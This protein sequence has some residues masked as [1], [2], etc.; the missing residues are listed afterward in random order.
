MSIRLGGVAAVST[1][2]V[3]GVPG[4][5]LALDH[6]LAEDAADLPLGRPSSASAGPV[7][8]CA[9]GSAAEPP[10]A[11]ARPKAAGIIAP[12]DARRCWSSVYSTT[13]SDKTRDWSCK[14]DRHAA[15][16]SR[17]GRALVCQAEVITGLTMWNS[18][19]P[20]GE[21]DGGVIER[22]VWGVRG[23]VAPL[24]I[25]Q[26]VIVLRFAQAKQGR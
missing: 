19:H 21:A 4:A 23:H 12:A 15:P 2:R 24:N 8:H 11:A 1:R 22:C 10:P 9:S 6:E 14:E 16:V 25:L 7:A 20:E 26:E 3:R 17:S 5:Q 18:P 13:R